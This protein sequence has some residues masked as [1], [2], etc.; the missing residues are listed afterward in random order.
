[1]GIVPAS[2]SKKVVVV[3]GGPAG[4]E[5][6][7]VSALRGYDVTLFESTGR[8][9]GAL[10]IGGVPDFKADDIALIGWYEHQLEQLKVDVRL[11]TKATKSNIQ[12]L[13]PDI[14]YVAAGSTPIELKV[15]DID[16]GKVV[17][18]TEVLAANTK[19]GTKCVIIGGGLVGCELALHLKNNGHE[20]T[21]VEVQNDILQTGVPMAPMNEWML[22]DL[23][24][25]NK[26]TIV[27]NTQLSK[28]TST[29]A[30]VISGGIET[31]LPADNIILAI[32]FTSTNTL[33]EE[34]KLDYGQIYNLGDGKRVRNIRAAIWDAYEVA[35]SI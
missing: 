16:C 31:V 3:G 20:V 4:M 19:V 6:A 5:A 9:G 7:R 28:V 32:G 18:A 17:N 33:Y 1:V 34:L 22:R 10:V 27:T 30:V 11:N 2:Q 25:F 15:P 29:S 35:R 12:E 21:I 26:I 8:L 24:A 13:K 14:V 23:L